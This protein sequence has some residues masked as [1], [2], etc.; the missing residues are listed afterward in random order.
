MNIKENLSQL[1]N[2]KKNL[3]YWAGIV[4]LADLYLIIVNAVSFA[5][6]G[7][8]RNYMM[9]GSSLH[10]CTLSEFVKFGWA[11]LSFNNVL[12]FLPAV[13]TMVFA[14]QIVDIIFAK[15]KQR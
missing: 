4:L 1:S 9:L 10:A 12:I 5:Q 11:W 14:T 6:T 13:L 15:D 8:C 3:Y 2:Q 7:Q